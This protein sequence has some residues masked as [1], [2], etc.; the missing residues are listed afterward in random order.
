MIYEF[1]RLMVFFDLPTTTK[2]DVKVYNKF[3][4]YLIKN[5]YIMLQYSVYCK[6]FPNRE[7]VVNHV[8]ILKRNVPQNG[9][10]R[11]MMITE[12]QFSRMELIVGGKSMQEEIIT[13][14]SLIIL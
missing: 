1:M 2:A 3:R 13:D 7:A 4:K 12:K 10:I 6:I 8:N 5:G 9:N 14:E 11:I